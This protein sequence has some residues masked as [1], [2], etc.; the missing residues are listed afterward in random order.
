MSEPP[1]GWE[2]PPPSRQAPEDRS[3]SITASLSLV[4]AG[5]CWV[6]C[7]PPFS[8][9]AI[10]LATYSLVAGWRSPNVGA[11]IAAGIGMALGIYH[12]LW[13][14]DAWQRIFG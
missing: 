2:V 4:F 9:C 8:V 14:A 10:V 7:G 13:A 3:P 12:A 1:G 11:K 5:L 6:M